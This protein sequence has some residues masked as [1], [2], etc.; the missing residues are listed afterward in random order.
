MMNAIQFYNHKE[1]MIRTSV[2]NIVL[3]LTKGSILLLLVSLIGLIPFI[4]QEL[5]LCVILCLV[6]FA[7]ERLVLY[8]QST[9]PK[10]N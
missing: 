3:G 5:P 9:R 7:N 8:H 10:L 6:L 4:Y 1:S 2:R